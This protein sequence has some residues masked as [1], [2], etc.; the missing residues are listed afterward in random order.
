MLQLVRIPACPHDLHQ[1][2]STSDI[3]N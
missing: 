2:C 3:C 1:I